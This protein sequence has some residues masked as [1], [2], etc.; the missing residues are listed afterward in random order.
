MPWKNLRAIYSDPPPVF[1][2]D[3]MP[4]R[5]EMAKIAHQLLR[6]RAKDDAVLAAKMR[7]RGIGL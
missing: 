2:P 7:R 5:E 3:A 4:T 1:D 6:E